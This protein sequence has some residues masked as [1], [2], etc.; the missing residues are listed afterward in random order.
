MY[1]NEI[2]VQNGLPITDVIVVSVY[3]L[4]NNVLAYKA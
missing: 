4:T 1:T 2:I 3:L